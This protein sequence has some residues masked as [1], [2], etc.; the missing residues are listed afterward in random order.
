MRSTVQLLTSLLLAR[1]AAVDGQDAAGG[2]GQDH[3]AGV[4][5]Q[6]H[7]DLD[8]SLNGRCDNGRCRCEP[9]W[10]GAPD[11]SSI[12]FVPGTRASGYRHH[13]PY[14]APNS[15][16]WG[17]GGWYDNTSGLYLMW[18]SEMAGNW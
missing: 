7:S 11:C 13:E 2:S 18:V 1:C 16:S 5:G 9:A 6:C 10:S 15:S 14:L 12:R 17:G 8:F 4:V 3:V